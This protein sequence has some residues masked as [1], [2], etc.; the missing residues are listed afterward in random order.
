[1]TKRMYIMP[2]VEEDRGKGLNHFYPKYLDTKGKL[3]NCTEFLLMPYAFAGLCVATAEVDDFNHTVIAGQA[4]VW[5]VPDVEKLNGEV[6]KDQLAYFKAW[7]GLHKMP[8]DGLVEGITFKELIRYF[9]GMI[10]NSQILAHQRGVDLNGKELEVNFGSLNKAEKDTLDE[11]YTQKG[12]DKTKFNN[13]TT[14]SNVLQVVA[15]AGKD[16]PVSIAGVEV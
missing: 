12:Y 11:L 15:D 16:I 2:I 6:D 13:A 9:N 8:T 1:M 7:V 3:A 10:Q 4:D 5:T 14:L